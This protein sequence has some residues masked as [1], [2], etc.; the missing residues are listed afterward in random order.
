MVVCKCITM[1]KSGREA[2]ETSRGGSWNLAD[3]WQILPRRVCACALPLLRR[4]ASKGSGTGTVMV[5]FQSLLTKNFRM[6][7]VGM[8]TPLWVII[9]H[10]LWSAIGPA[11]RRNFRVSWVAT[12]LREMIICGL[13][14]TTLRG[15]ISSNFQ[16]AYMIYYISSFFSPKPLSQGTCLIG[17]L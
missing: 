11:V 12:D 14:K 17:S 3:F 5:V 13:S 9:W 10:N 4:G 8:G 16:M 7:S 6:Y 2:S 15:Q 1:H